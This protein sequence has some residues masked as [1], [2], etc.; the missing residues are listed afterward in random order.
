[1]SKSDEHAARKRIDA[2][3]NY[4]RIMETIKPFIQR[5]EKPKPRPREVWRRGEDFPEEF[6]ERFRIEHHLTRSSRDSTSE[7]ASR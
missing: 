6:N 5:H 2:Q 4:E 1:M 3:N 7:N